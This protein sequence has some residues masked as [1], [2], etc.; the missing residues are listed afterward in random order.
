MDTVADKDF[1]EHFERFISIMTDPDNFTKEKLLDVLFALSRLFRISK[2]VT[3]FYVDASRENAGDGEIFCDYDDGRGGPAVLKLRYVTPSQAVIKG[4]IYRPES[5]PPFSENDLRRLETVVRALLSFVSR[6]RLAQALEQYAFNDDRGYPNLR[7]Y[8]RRLGTLYAQGK[9]SGS[10]TALLFN[11]K[12]FTLINQDIGRDN[13]DIVM[14]KYYDMLVSAVGRSGIVARVGGDNFIMLFRNVHTERI[15]GILRGIPV[16]YG[17]ADDSRVMLSASAGVYPIPKEFVF[18][19]QGDI[20]DKLM[21][22]SQAAKHSQR[23]LIVYY[24]Y[25]MVKQNYKSMRIQQL[26][27][28]ALTEREFRVYYQP[29]VD[30]ETGRIVG[31]EA[32]CRWFHDGI[33]IPPMEFIPILEQTTDVCRLDFYMLDSVCADIRRWL[34][35]GKKP[36]RISVNLSRKHLADVDLL[37]HLM[38]IIERHS[39]PHE[40]IEIELTETTTD[41]EF[42]DLK[43]IVSGLQQMGVR[44]SV[45][46]FGVGYSSLN[47]IREI[48]WNVLKID[49]CFLPMD[50]ESESSVTSMM[51]RHVVSMALEMGLECITEGVE[52]ARQIEILRSNGCRIAQGFVFDKPLPIEEFE[53]LLGGYRYRLGAAE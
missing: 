36:V 51:Y 2:G 52:T 31:A 32:L 7:A 24:D 15:F 12:R 37:K 27:P 17:S 11:L 4:T 23:D 26:F 14:R 50:D 47:L 3:E 10:Y 25:G 18:N 28:R 42:R 1:C 38:E 40:Y 45:D 8:M 22:S 5:E 13:G 29:K 33:M 53:K 35:T 46:D 41:V 20:M 30:V 44:T 43:R 16:S 21:S 19:T 48:P 39:V 34:D 49:R 9:L 6:N